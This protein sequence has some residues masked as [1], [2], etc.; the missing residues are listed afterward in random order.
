MFSGGSACELIAL[1]STK[2]SSKPWNI[3]IYIAQTSSIDY[4]ACKDVLHSKKLSWVGGYPL[5]ISLEEADLSQ[6]VPEEVLHNEDL[7]GACQ[8]Y[9]TTDQDHT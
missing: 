6:E 2:E 7:D 3:S 5:Q 8:A 4:K 9:R 1:N